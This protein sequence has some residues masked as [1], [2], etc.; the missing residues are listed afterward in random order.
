MCACSLFGMSTITE[1]QGGE[2]VKIATRHCRPSSESSGL[3]RQNVT[4]GGQATG[5]IPASR[6]SAPSEHRVEDLDQRPSR[7]GGSSEI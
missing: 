1:P 3:R 2:A 7:R 4:S 6:V 5:P